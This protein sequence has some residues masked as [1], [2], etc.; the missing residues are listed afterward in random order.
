MDKDPAVYVSQAEAGAPHAGNGSLDI[1]A[2]EMTAW[3]ARPPPSPPLRGRGAVGHVLGD[4]DAHRARADH[5]HCLG[6]P[7]ASATPT[8]LPRRPAPTPLATAPTA[9]TVT[10][11]NPVT[12]NGSQDTY[13]ATPGAICDSAQL[14]PTSR[15]EPDRR[16]ILAGGLPGR[17]GP[18]DATSSTG[19]GTEIDYGLGSSIS[20]ARASAGF[21]TVNTHRSARDSA[22]AEGR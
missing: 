15:W 22:A 21:Q 19:T 5:Y 3:R 11:D 2:A 16:R 17:V 1:G 12:P 9:F 18:A 10:G 20:K 7:T 6:H 8:S 14:K 4:A 13:A